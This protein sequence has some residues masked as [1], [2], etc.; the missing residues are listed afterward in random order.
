MSA[1]NVKGQSNL[2]VVLL[3]ML[4]NEICRA[5]YLGSGGDA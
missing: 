5:P 3:D 1:P 2:E 4:G